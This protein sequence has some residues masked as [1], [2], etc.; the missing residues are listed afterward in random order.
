[1]TRL[2]GFAVSGLL[3]VLALVPAAAASYGL[4]TGATSASVRV[5]RSGS[6][7]VTWRANGQTTSFVVPTSGQGYHGT[8][9]TD[10]SKPASLALPMAITVRRAPNGTLYALQVFKVGSL[11]VSL[12]VSRWHGAPTAV[13]LSLAGDHL[14]GTVTFDGKPVSGSSP[15]LAGR[16]ARIFVYLECLGCQGS[17]TT[18]QLM[19]GVSPK[20]DG[21][22]RVFLRP[23]WVG[24]RYRATVQ[25]PNVD[26]QLAP[27]ARTVIAA[28]G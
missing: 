14:T 12:D 18:W 10:V 19:L 21:T 1:V 23:S 24:T 2:P 26:G 13:T 7:G 22:F 3:A 4:T 5:D 17:P 28:A 27:D 6:A 11:P 15:T 9:S 8:V 25:G 16:A 20:S